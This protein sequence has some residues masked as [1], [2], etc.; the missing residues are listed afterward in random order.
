M[1]TY[2]IERLQDNGDVLLC[3]EENNKQKLISPSRSQGVINHSPTGFNYGYA[4]SGPAQLALAIL[5]DDY[6]DHKKAAA[7]HQHFKHVAIAKMD[8]TVNKH[9]ITSEQIDNLLKE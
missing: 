7:N 6:Q 1:K 8:G 2:I 9:Q 3:V 4:G 5:I